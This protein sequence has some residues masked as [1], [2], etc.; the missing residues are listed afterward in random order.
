MLFDGVQNR[1]QHENGAS[2]PGY[3]RRAHPTASGAFAAI[4][5]GDMTNFSTYRYIFSEACDPSTGIWLTSFLVGAS[6]EIQIQ[7]FGGAGTGSALTGNGYITNGVPFVMGVRVESTLLTLWVNRTKILNAVAFD[8]N[9]QSCWLSRRSLGAQSTGTGA[10]SA[11]QPWLGH[12]AETL[13]W[14]AAVFPSEAVF[15]TYMDWCHNYYEI[16]Y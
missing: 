9:N 3:T 12:S 13:F 10:G 16:P 11:N 5:V 4:F 1:L 6:G 8:G 15:G 14:N 2:S 7:R